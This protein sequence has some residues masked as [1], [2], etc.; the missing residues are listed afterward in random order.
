MISPLLVDQGSTIGL[1]AG[2]ETNIVIR[3]PPTVENGE[4]SCNQAMCSESGP[5]TQIRPRPNRV[6][7]THKVNLNPAITQNSAINT[8][9]HG[10]LLLFSDY[11]PLPPSR[12]SLSFLSFFHAR[13]R[14]RELLFSPCLLWSAPAAVLHVYPRTGPNAADVAGLTPLRSA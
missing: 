1:E 5:W 6:Y 2:K 9:I 12:Q 3:L 8:I 13:W 7:I 10:A 4:S 14:R 11:A